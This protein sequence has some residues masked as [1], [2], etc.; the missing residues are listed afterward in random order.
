DGVVGSLRRGVPADVALFNVENGEFPLVDT[1]KVSRTIPVRLQNTLTLV[2]G[3]ELPP[4][5]PNERAPW[6]RRG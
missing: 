1:R 5:A 6:M 3:R 2:G 4:E